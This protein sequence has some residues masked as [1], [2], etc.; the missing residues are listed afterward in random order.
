MFS[1]SVANGTLSWDDAGAPEYYVFAINGG[2]ES[3]LGGHTTT[4]LTVDA[5]DSYRVEHWN[6]GPAT[7]ALCGG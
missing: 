1:C 4:S 2:V 6:N 3:Y 7:N 5:A